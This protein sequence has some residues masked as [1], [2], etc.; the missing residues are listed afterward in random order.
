M[1]LVDKAAAA[2]V[3]VDIGRQSTEKIAVRLDP[4]L[5]WSGLLLCCDVRGELRMLASSRA[6]FMSLV[7]RETQDFFRKRG[8]THLALY[9]SHGQPMKRQERLAQ[10]LAW[11]EFLIRDHPGAEGKNTERGGCFRPL[12]WA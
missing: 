10:C 3:V 9:G 11:T 7:I 8:E 5:A 12:T 4:D 6:T 2:V 1:I